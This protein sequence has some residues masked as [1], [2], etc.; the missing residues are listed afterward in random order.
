VLATVLGVVDPRADQLRAMRFPRAMSVG[1]V[2]WAG[3]ALGAAL[4]VWALHASLVVPLGINQQGLV[5]ASGVLIL[6]SGVC[7]LVLIRPHAG[8][9]PA[10]SMAVVLACCLHVPVYLIHVRLMSHLAGKGHCPYLAMEGLGTEH[11]LLR[12][13]EGALIVAIIIL[14]RPNARLLAS[15]SLVVRTGRV[16]RQSL[17]TLAAVVGV[18]ALGDLVGL[19]GGVVSTRLA[20]VL[21]PL[22]DILIGMGSLLFTIGLVGILIDSW[23]LA[24]VIAHPAPGVRETF[25]QTDG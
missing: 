4:L 18:G 17:L 14:L 7:A 9:S 6:A 15:R 11:H 20:G 3:F 21:V 13:G 10:R 22:S 8:V 19:L 1:L 24:P 5:S 23:R 2:L 16:D 12:L 25:G